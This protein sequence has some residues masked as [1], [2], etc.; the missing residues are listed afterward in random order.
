MSAVDHT[1]HP[2]YD[3]DDLPPG[4]LAELFVTAVEKYGDRLA[5]QYFPDESSHLEGITFDE[6]YEIVGA[7]AAGLQALG[8]GPG[9]KVAILADNSPEWA[10]ADFACLCVGILD[11]PIYSTLTISQV[12]YILKNSEVQ[13]VFVSDISQVRK[14]LEASRQI[15]RDVRVVMFGS[16]EPPEDG[17]L[18]WR[19]FLERGR[20]AAVDS[21]Q[22]FR[23]K[24]LEAGPEDV[25]TVLYTSGT[26]GDP[27]GVMLTHHNISSNVRSI[28]R[29]LPSTTG[30]TSLVFL[31]LSHVFQRT[32][33]YFHFSSGVIQTFAILYPRWPRT[34]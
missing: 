7:A 21:D 11:V 30:D 5:Y 13:L 29:I 9:D 33:S 19:N 15:E 26:T 12:A 18:V 2:A 22:A 8:L 4:T 3:Q 31:P 6:V 24:A 28:T 20:N 34:S 25:A 23:A 14:V 16:T 32:G 1:S 17:V 27:K 10:L